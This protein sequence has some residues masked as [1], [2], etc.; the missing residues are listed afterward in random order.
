MSSVFQLSFSAAFQLA[1]LIS[2]S[3]KNNFHVYMLHV[4][5]FQILK[6][7]Y[8]HCGFFVVYGRKLIFYT[9][10]KYY[11]IYVMVLYYWSDN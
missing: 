11:I 1:I 10:I 4:V 8:C 5:G 7:D 2:N 9:Y 6:C 3:S